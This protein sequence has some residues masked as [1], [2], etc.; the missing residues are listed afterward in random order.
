VTR[1]THRHFERL[2]DSIEPRPC[3]DCLALPSRF[4]AEPAGVLPATWIP[5]SLHPLISGAPQAWAPYIDTGLRGFF[6][7]PD[8][9]EAW[10]MSFD[11]YEGRRDID[12]LPASFLDQA[13]PSGRLEDAW[14]L[15]AHTGSGRRLVTAFFAKASYDRAAA[16][17]GLLA[18]V[19][20]RDLTAH[21]VVTLLADIIAMLRNA[22][23]DSAV[24]EADLG[25]L[26]RLPNRDDVRADV[27]AEA[28]RAMIVTALT[29]AV[30]AM[31][32][33]G[34][35]VRTDATQREALLRIARGSVA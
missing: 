21:H 4:Y 26:V 22:P 17:R 33:G 14:P 19:D 30:E 28:R 8:C 9:S 7:C 2:L 34:D 35:R 32:E 3:A 24:P 31:F 13:Q 16:L 23:P 10:R 27:A 12:R 20:M 15:L 29:P 18:A 25:P 6:F 1:R 11:Q 5:L